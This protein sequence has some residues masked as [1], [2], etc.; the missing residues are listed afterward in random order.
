M[1]TA[2]AIISKYAWRTHVL[3]AIS[4]TEVHL[5]RESCEAVTAC[6]ADYARH[7]AA[8][9]TFHVIET[10]STGRLAHPPRRLWLKIQ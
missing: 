4:V 2:I 9:N 1:H 8:A 10:S 6:R 3:Y 7:S 5:L